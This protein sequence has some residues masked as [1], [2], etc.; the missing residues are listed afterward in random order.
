MKEIQLIA[1][2]FSGLTTLGMILL[3]SLLLPVMVFFPF[4]SSGFSGHQGFPLFFYTWT[5]C[6]PPFSHFLW[7][8]LILDFL[9]LLAITIGCGI[10]LERTVIA[11]LRKKFI[12]EH[13]EQQE[14]LMSESRLLGFSACL[15]SAAGILLPLLIYN[16]WC[17]A[18]SAGV[19]A[20]SEAFALL[21]GI[22]SWRDRLGKAAIAGAMLF[23]A[24]PVMFYVA[25][26]MTFGEFFPWS[27][28]EW[29]AKYVKAINEQPEP[30]RS[31][32]VA[33]RAVSSDPHMIAYKNAVQKARESFSPRL[34]AQLVSLIDT[35]SMLGNTAKDL[36]EGIYAGDYL[37]DESGF[38]RIPRE[39]LKQAM[40]V[41][42]DSM[43]Q[44][45][46]KGALMSCLLIF[47]K[48]TGTETAEISIPFFNETVKVS[49]RH[50]ATGS[51]TSCS[52]SG[53]DWKNRMEEI[54]PIF[55]QYC[56][57]RLH[58]IEIGTERSAIP[59]TRD[60]LTGHSESEH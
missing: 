26:P 18:P 46:G 25:S 50:D 47:V 53:N 20:C 37:V 42:I 9:F 16:R 39:K 1:P 29:E 58:D 56:R 49:Y 51:S 41:L 15:F 17:F 38:Y 33:T 34:T 19:W 36:L 7:W 40:Q 10:L 44:A 27:S 6:G 23:I 13:V 31:F 28:A 57:Q 30:I 60:P 21:L 48:A 45:K 24:L 5:D 3:W 55:Q 32:L 8:N 14:S 11:R 2:H 43:G 59:L 22:F 4:N 12:K 52:Y 54:I 35:D